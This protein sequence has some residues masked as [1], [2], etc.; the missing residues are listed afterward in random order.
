MYRY[1]QDQNGDIFMG[2]AVE[3]NYSSFVVVFV[4]DFVVLIVKHM[5]GHNETNLDIQSIL[6]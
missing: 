6:R 2:Q 1:I 3:S 4:I 5:S